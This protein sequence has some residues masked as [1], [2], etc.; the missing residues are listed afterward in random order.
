[1]HGPSVARGRRM[2]SGPVGIAAAG[3]VAFD[4]EEIL[5]GECQAVERPRGDRRLLE[6]R[7]RQEGAEIHH[8]LEMTL[9][10][11]A[12]T[13]QPSGRRAQLC[14]WRPT[15]PGGVSRYSVETVANVSPNS[16]M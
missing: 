5:G 4:V 14:I 10:W 2:R 3:D 13:R 7:T 6:A 8:G 1:M 9:T 15:V 12:T 11:A 16:V